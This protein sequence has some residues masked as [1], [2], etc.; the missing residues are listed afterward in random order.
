MV[1]PMIGIFGTSDVEKDGDLLYP[2]IFRHLLEKS[3][4]SL[5][6]TAYAFL[7]GPAPAAAMPSAPTSPS[8]PPM[9]PDSSLGYASVPVWLRRKLSEDRAIALAY[10]SCGVPFAER[11]L[12]RLLTP[13]SPS[14][15]YRARR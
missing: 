15:R 6:T 3:R 5:P 1:T 11:P 9:T 8:W 2:S 10:W 12:V 4:V 14:P 13:R 7:P